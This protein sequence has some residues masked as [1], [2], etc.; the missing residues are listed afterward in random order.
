MKEARRLNRVHR[1]VLG[2]LKIKPVRIDL[3]KRGI[4]Y[5]LRTGW[6]N[7]R[8][9]ANSLCRQFAARNQGCIVVRS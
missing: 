7:D 4:F 8:V 3:G 2:N 5:R 6:F 1:A 9:A